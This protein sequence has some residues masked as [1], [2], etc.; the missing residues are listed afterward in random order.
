M[1]LVFSFRQFIILRKFFNIKWFFQHLLS[2]LFFFPTSSCEYG[3]SDYWYL[4]AKSF[5]YSKHKHYLA[6]MVYPFFIFGS[7][8]LLTFLFRNFT[9]VIP[10]ALVSS[11]GFN[12]I[13]MLNPETDLEVIPLYL[14]TAWVYLFKTEVIS[15]LNIWKNAQKIYL[16]LESGYD[17]CLFYY[18]YFGYFWKGL[19]AYLISLQYL[20][21]F[22]PKNRCSKGLISLHR[23][24]K[25]RNIMQ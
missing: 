22:F 16:D 5:I 14:L 3:W 20:S 12:T 1:S 25:A 23:D 18:Y 7:F 21:V 10:P 24:L 19:I 17:L 9:F 15:S 11:L 13:D 6:M 2:C 4:S 8:D